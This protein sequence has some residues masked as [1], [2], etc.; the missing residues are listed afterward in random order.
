M[1][2]GGGPASV[3]HIFGYPLGEIGKRCCRHRTA[4]GVT[5]R[6]TAPASARLRHCRA[7]RTGDGRKLFHC[8]IT[9]RVR[10]AVSCGIGEDGHRRRVPAPFT[11]THDRRAALPCHHHAAGA[12]DRAGTSRAVGGSADLSSIP[13]RGPTTH[14]ASCGC[15][16]C[17]VGPG[18]GAP[19]KRRTEIARR[20]PAGH[21][22]K[23]LSRRDRPRAASCP[24]GPLAR[25]MTG[26]YLALAALAITCGI[27]VPGGPDR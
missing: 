13:D 15:R 3:V 10:L 12:G 8:A 1:R 23:R 25:Q 11:E 16:V 18:A 2:R 21:R 5:L 9:E 20:R 26:S 6:E 19:M 22:S 4:V 7:R 24:F 14:I 17:Q 27:S